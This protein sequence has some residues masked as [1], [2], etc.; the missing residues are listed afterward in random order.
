MKDYVVEIVRRGSLKVRADTAEEAVAM[1]SQFGFGAAAWNDDFDVHAEA[2]QDGADQ[3]GMLVKV[4]EE[5][6]GKGNKKHRTK[7]RWKFKCRCDDGGVIADDEIP[8]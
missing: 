4:G 3:G 8:F 1:A 7:W 5:T 2:A 6:K